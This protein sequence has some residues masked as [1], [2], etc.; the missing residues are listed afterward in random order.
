MVNLH[1]ASEHGL[2]KVLGMAAFISK[3]SYVNTYAGNW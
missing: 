1:N 3:Q 2:P